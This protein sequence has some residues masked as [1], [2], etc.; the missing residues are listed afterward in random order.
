MSA[1][2]KHAR[3]RRALLMSSDFITRRGGRQASSLARAVLGSK[4][5]AMHGL[6]ESTGG[7]IPRRRSDNRI[8]TTLWAEGRG[9]DTGNLVGPLGDRR[10]RIRPKA[11]ETAAN[12]ASENFVPV[13]R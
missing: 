9:T 5:L 1:Q 6:Q 11:V 4:P 2:A 3:K 10:R 7:G 12:I 13:V 8:D